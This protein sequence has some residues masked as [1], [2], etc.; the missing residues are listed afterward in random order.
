VD[1][2]I[3]RLV[4]ESDPWIAQDPVVQVPCLAQG[5]ASSLKTL[6]LDASRRNPC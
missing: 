4:N 5:T 1:F 2:D 6:G 3:A